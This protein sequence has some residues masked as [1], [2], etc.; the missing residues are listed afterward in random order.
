MSVS[1]LNSQDW[2]LLQ[3]NE[4]NAGLRGMFGKHGQRHREAIAEI[5]PHLKS[6]LQQPEAQSVSD[7]DNVRAALEMAK[8]A[9]IEP[10]W[11]TGKVYK[12]KRN[13]ENAILNLYYSSV[14]T[15]S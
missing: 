13:L 8:E 10:C 3:E 1:S 12:N 9:G 6:R 2:R 15:E 11:G 7:R 4:P 14:M 5:L